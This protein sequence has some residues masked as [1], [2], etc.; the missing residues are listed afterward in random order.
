[1]VILDP[2]VTIGHILD[3]DYRAESVAERERFE[4]SMGQ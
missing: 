2:P 1:M 3:L 4:L